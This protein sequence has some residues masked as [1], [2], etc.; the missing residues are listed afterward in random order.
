MS[1]LFIIGNGFDIAHGIPTKYSDF[2]EFILGM[3]P[4]AEKNSKKIVSLEYLN[5][6]SPE[7]IAAEFLI[8]AMDVACGK[9]WADFEDALSRIHFF[10]KWPKSH[11]EDDED[12]DRE[13]AT[14]H[15]L[16]MMVMNDKVIQS[17]MQWQ[18]FLSK[19]IRN[20]E[21]RI[22]AGFYNTKESIKKEIAKNESVFITF[23][24]TK[25]LQVLYDI[26]KVIHIHNRVG[27]KLIFGHGED[28]VSYQEPEFNGSFGSSFL[29]DMLMS[30]KKDTFSQLRKYS[31][32]FNKLHMVDKVYSYGFSFSKVDSVYIKRIIQNISPNT[33]WFFTKFESEDTSQ[34]RIKKL[35]LRRYGFKGSFDVYDG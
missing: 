32:E 18:V 16:K 34:I 24:Y 26:K 28:E 1:T 3:Y 22:D 23:N 8:C 33:T 9:T 25:T 29:D 2:R 21:N 30:L 15:L 5:R 20:V 13:Q 12:A 14:N 35:K 7:E 19:W 10:D 6:K 11:H 17:I 4:N 27:Q 31:D